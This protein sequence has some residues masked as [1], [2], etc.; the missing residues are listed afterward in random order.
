MKGWANSY[1]D[2]F[3]SEENT[4]I[5]WWENERFYNPF[6]AFVDRDRFW[7]NRILLQE[8]RIMNGRAFLDNEQIV[9]EE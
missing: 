9:L 4:G 8:A 1:L 3:L 7:L 5:Q 6:R 2:E